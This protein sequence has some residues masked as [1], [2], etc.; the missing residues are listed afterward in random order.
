MYGNRGG[1]FHR[2]DR[3]LGAARWKSKQWIVCVLDFKGRRNDVFGKRYT[4]LFFVDE[5]TAFA[6][7][8]RPC[9]YC[10]R[11]AALAFVRAVGD[12]ELVRAQKL[13]ARLDGER[14]VG[15]DKRLH[16]AG[17]DDLPDGA[18]F[19]KDA[20]AFAVKGDRILE[21]SFSGYRAAQARPK[22]VVVDALTPPTILRAL[23]NG[24]APQWHS[25]ARG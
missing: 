24:Y 5:P 17:L 1:R 11:A 16:E 10:R 22:G 2:D 4:D 25:S 3:T 20:R 6:A 18:M 21:W 19:L 12:P 7:G 23:G 13:D 9:F 15:R 14:R 8:H